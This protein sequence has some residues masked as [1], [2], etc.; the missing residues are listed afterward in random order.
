MVVEEVQ[1]L[2]NVNSKL[3]LN[4]HKTEEEIVNT[5][6]ALRN[7]LTGLRRALQEEIQS[8]TSLLNK[9]ATETEDFEKYQ[10]VIAH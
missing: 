3:A 1:R 9:M 5:E 7:S 6:N 2:A 8:K 10:K 4:A